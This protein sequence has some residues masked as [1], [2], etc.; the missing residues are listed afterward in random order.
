MRT[1]LA[2]LAI[3]ALPLA[4]PSIADTVDPNAVHPDVAYALA[5]EPGG[6]ATSYFGAEWPQLGM[7]LTVPAGSL[8]AKDVGQ[9]ATGNI[10]AFSG[11]SQ[12]GTRLSWST[13]G[14][15]SVASL[16]T[17]GSITNARASGTMYAKQG[18]TTRASASAGS[19]AT[20]GAGY[21]SLITSVGC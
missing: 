18:S 16:P 1:L 15:K 17:V 9:C 4:A 7:T 13:C 3:A 8:A 14:A 5:A 20:V 21:R 2:I 6:H 12:S 19:T 10:C 11:T